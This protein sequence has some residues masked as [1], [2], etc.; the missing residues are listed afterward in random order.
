MAARFEGSGLEAVIGVVVKGICTAARTQL[1]RAAVHSR[2]QTAEW[3]SDLL[4]L[5]VKAGECR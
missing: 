2:V 5:R 3:L 4:Q 1:L